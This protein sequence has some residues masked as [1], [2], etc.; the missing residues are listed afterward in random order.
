MQSTKSNY[1]AFTWGVPFGSFVVLFFVISAINRR[2]NWF[3][4]GTI[5]GI[6]TKSMNNSKKAS[7]WEPPKKNG[8][9][10]RT[11][12]GKKE[13]QK[14]KSMQHL[15]TCKQCQTDFAVIVEKDDADTPFEKYLYIEF[16]DDEVAVPELKCFIRFLS[17]LM[18]AAILAVFISIIFIK[19]IL[20][21]EI[22]RNGRKCPKYDADCFSS[23]EKYD[24]SPYSC[25]DGQY[26]NIT[27]YNGLVWC[28]GWVY[29]DRSAQDVLDTLGTCGGLL[30]IVSCIVP[31]VYYLSYYK[32]C[33]LASCL[34]IILPIGGVL[35]LALMLWVTWYDGPSQLGITVVSVVIVMIAIGWC[36]ALWRSCSSHES[37]SSCIPRCSCFAPKGCQYSRGCCHYRCC[38]CL[39]HIFC[40]KYTWYPWACI[41]DF[42]KYLCCMF[43][44]TNLSVY[45]HCPAACETAKW[46][47]TPSKSNRVTTIQPY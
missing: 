4:L 45:D 23:D 7:N 20:S 12:A 19:L 17:D 10:W 15:V 29:K 40:G 46:S 34:C 16:E 37:E 6:A 8:T 21:N 27:G 33:H 32:R 35:G 25:T 9:D 24:F 2:T 44:N 28:V 18:V 41:R 22:I 31:L 5:L 38:F 47:K 39:F 1:T 13:D 43:C 11:Q 30:G 42:W 3:L 14:N 26:I 36:W